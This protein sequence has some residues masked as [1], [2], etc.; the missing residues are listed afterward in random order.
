M[1]HLM[2]SLTVN[3]IFILYEY[4][5]INVHFMKPYRGVHY[6]KVVQ[7]SIPDDPPSCLPI[8]HVSPYTL[9]H[10][11]WLPATLVIGDV[12]DHATFRGK[13]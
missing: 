12:P 5:V 11:A 4:L 3:G 9:R 7:F 10:L 8:M 6:D 13:V 2:S 1:C